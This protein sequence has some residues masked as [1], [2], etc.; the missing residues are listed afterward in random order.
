LKKFQWIWNSGD[1]KLEIKI[2]LKISSS[3]CQKL[4]ASKVKFYSNSKILTVLAYGKNSLQPVVVWSQDA[5]FLQIWVQNSK[6]KFAGYSWVKTVEYHRT[7]Q[8]NVLLE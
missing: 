3:K 1:L 5:S 6:K 2:F 4:F 7:Q 8:A